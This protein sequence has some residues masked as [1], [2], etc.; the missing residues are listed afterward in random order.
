LE[1]EVT[2]DPK[3]PMSAVFAAQIER[4][5]VRGA[6]FGFETIKHD[7]S[8]DEE[9]RRVRTLLEVRLFDV[10]PVTY[11]AYPASEVDRRALDAATDSVANL[12]AG[13]DL[14]ELRSILLQVRD[15]QAPLAARSNYLAHLAAL[16]AL[17]P[18]DPSPPVETDWS[19]RLALHER[20]A[21]QGSPAQRMFKR[22]TD[23]KEYSTFEACVLDNGWADDPEGYCQSIKTGAA[24]G[25]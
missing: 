6:S 21:R 16:Q 18:P 1:G 17:L 14:A 25:E 13:I 19:R 11:P 22:P 9:G 4:G 5:D 15:G 8:Y 24:P 7:L 20:F 12:C 3:N 10:S 23:G 2:L